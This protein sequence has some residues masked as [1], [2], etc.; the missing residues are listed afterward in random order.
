MKW[1]ISFKDAT[2][3]V[4][5]STGN[6]TVYFYKAVTKPKTEVKDPTPVSAKPTIDNI[7]L[8]AGATGDEVAIAG[9]N[10]STVL[11]ENAVKFNGVAATVK[12]AT[13]TK[14]TVTVPTST[15]GAVTVKVNNSETVT[16]PIFTYVLPPTVTGVTP[17]S[18]KAGDVVTI[19][20]TNFS[21][22]LTENVV[23]F[24]GT[25]ATVTDA[26]TTQLK[27]TVPAGVTSGLVT[28]KVRGKDAAVTGGATVNTFTVVNPANV[29]AISP[30][31]GV[32]GTQVTIT[33]TGFSTILSDNVV[34]FNGVTGVPVSATA[35]TLVVSAPTG[36]TTGAIT[37]AVKGVPATIGAGV[38]A[39]FTVVAASNFGTPGQAYGLTAVYFETSY[40]A[41]DNDD[42]LWLVDSNG[43][44]NKE[45]Y[46]GGDQLKT[47]TAAN[48]TFASL[49]SYLCRG[50]ARDANGGIHAYIYGSASN[51]QG[52]PSFVVTISS[53][54]VVTKDFETQ[55]FEKSSSGFAITPAGDVL[56]ISTRGGNSDI[57]R[58]KTDGTFEIYL[59]GGTGG[60]NTLGAANAY[61]MQVDGGNLYVLTYTSG[62]PNVDAV[63]AKFDANKTRTVVAALGN[64]GYVNGGLA[65]A[66]FN[67]VTCFA[68]SGS[69]IYIGDNGNQRIRKLNTTNNTVTTF[70]GL[71][72]TGTVYTGDA[73]SVTL[74]AVNGLL[75]D[76][77]HSVVYNFGQFT[78]EL[79]RIAY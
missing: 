24:N 58:L 62:S 25:A 1:D 75:V 36:V 14:L 30:I 6:F 66:K 76:P 5:T 63:I 50:I 2:G 74:N 31:Q 44:I 67:N 61:G 49:S 37:V 52:N 16:G 27:V 42:N 19:A 77:N 29:S 39:T 23:S 55:F 64:T 28:L 56:I 11:T 35:T 48:I 43:Q 33:G 8:T 15:T 13:A 46:T 72:T 3:R 65:D 53:A 71:G 7:A 78:H 79:T 73:L 40:K 12:T 34:T 4:F 22:V 26:T 57:W 54:G 10:F 41:V 17:L 38:T 60:D 69:S 51:G 45:A 20:G 59:K 21:T 32:A 9:T 70:A 68:V 47:I 18:G